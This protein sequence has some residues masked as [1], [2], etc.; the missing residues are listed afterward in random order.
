[1]AAE[2]IYH[3]LNA[4][5]KVTVISPSL[6]PEVAYRVSQ[7]QIRHIDRKFISN[8]LDGDVSM[9]LIAIDNPQESLMIWQLCKERRIPVNVADVPDECDFYFGSVYRDGPLQVMVSTNGNGPKM[10]NLVKR[11]IQGALPENMGAAI[12]NVGLLRSRLRTITSAPGEGP[13]RMKWIS[14]FC[15]QWTT[16]DLVNMDEQ[17]IEDILA[18]YASNT[19]PT[20]S[21][22]RR[23]R[24]PGFS[25]SSILTSTPSVR[26]RTRRSTGTPRSEQAHRENRNQTPSHPRS[27]HCHRLHHRTSSVPSS[28]HRYSS[29]YSDG[30]TMLSTLPSVS[31]NMRTDSSAFIEEEGETAVAEEEDE[32][33]E[34]YPLVLLH[35]T[36]LPPSLCIN[37]SLPF[38]SEQA[39][40]DALPEKY[41]RRWKILE[42]KVLASGVLRD[43]GMLISHPEDD[44]SLLEERIF[45]SLDLSSHSRADD[46]DRVRDALGSGATVAATATATTL[47]PGEHVSTNKRK[48]FDLRIY[49]ANGLMRSGA[50][51]A[52]WR[53]MEKVDVE[54][55]LSLPGEVRRGLEKRI[56]EELNAAAAVAPPHPPSPLSPHSE[57]GNGIGIGMSSRSL[58]PVAFDS[59]APPVAAKSQEISDEKNDTSKAKDDH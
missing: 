43:R 2:R 35:C 41:F 23:H 20:P 8:D 57:L 30:H 4:D 38:P 50:W 53:E 47:S 6:N 14:R 58:S 31:T 46:R 40:R 27:H 10:A 52:A 36:L 55:N 49:A 19:I 22:I 7:G 45:E 9:V 56:M 3:A 12:R 44:Y 15:E 21:D 25:D 59:G 18:F 39:L 33:E 5:A 51:R 1:V 37:P 34:E 29:Y 42:D 13:K 11:T 54:I 17:D 24:Y 48:P 28:I 32:E 16:R 26:P